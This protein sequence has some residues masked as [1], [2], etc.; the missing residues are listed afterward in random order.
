MISKDRV[1]GTIDD[2]LICCICDGVLDQPYQ[3]I[4]CGH[5]FCR[6]CIRQWLE[7]NDKCP[8]DVRF[9]LTNN[10][11]N[12]KPAPRIIQNMIDKVELSCEYASYG[13]E[14]FVRKDLMNNHLLKCDFNPNAK[15]HC[16]CGADFQ[17]SSH[18]KQHNCIKAFNFS[19]ES[20]KETLHKLHEKQE[21]QEKLITRLKSYFMYIFGMLSLNLLLFAYIV[22]S[23]I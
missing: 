23:Q 18:Q 3:S 4:G 6:L 19:I 7:V 21:E 10:R 11:A 22:M 14:Q 13:C 16:K 1:R 12:L 20:H 17:P 8:I 15:H 9:S 5:I 2:G